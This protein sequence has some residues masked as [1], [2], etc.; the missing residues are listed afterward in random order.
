MGVGTPADLLRF[1][2]MGYDLFDCVLPT[3]NG[4][5]GMLFTRE[6]KLMIRNARYARD[7]RPVEEGCGCYTCTHFSRGALR[8]LALVHD[9]LAG[10]LASLHNLHFYLRLMAEVRAAIAEGSFP[11]RAAAAAGA[12]AS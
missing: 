2:A 11:A 3:R 12:W 4:R 10:Q 8:H 6:G 5:N 9:T 7:A 1:V